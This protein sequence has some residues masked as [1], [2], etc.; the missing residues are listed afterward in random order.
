MDIALIIDWSIGFP[1]AKMNGDFAAKF[2]WACEFLFVY[3]L[4]GEFFLFK[5][6]K[7]DVTNS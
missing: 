1:L 4:A 3:S 6:I 7:I 2:I 5:I